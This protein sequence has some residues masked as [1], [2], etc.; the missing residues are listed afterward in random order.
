MYAIVEKP[1]KV[2]GNDAF[3]NFAVGVTKANPEAVEFGTGE[4]GF[5]LGL[6]VAVEFA[7]EIERADAIE[8][9]LLVFAFL[10]EEVK[11]IDLTKAGRIQVSLHGFAVHERDNNLLVGRGWGTEFQGLPFLAQKRFRLRNFG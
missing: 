8:G 7:D 5:A 3:E 2:I 4:E 9:D 11:R 6:E 10:R 1:E